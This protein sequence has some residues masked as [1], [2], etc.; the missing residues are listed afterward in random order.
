MGKAPKYQNL[1]AFDRETD[2]IGHIEVGPPEPIFR[3]KDGSPVRLPKAER[4]RIENERFEN[5]KA[6]PFA[7]Y[8]YDN[9]FFWYFVGT[10]VLI[11]VLGLFIWWMVK[12]P[13]TR[14]G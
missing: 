12:H 14:Y 13:P 3:K 11:A 1:P 7:S 4:K 9:K 10:F 8:G 6:H 5:W 2:R